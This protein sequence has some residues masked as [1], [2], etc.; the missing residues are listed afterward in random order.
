VIVKELESKDDRIRLQA[1]IILAA[2][3]EKARPAKETMKKIHAQS[4]GGGHYPMYIRWGLERALG[5]V[6]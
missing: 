2:L 4:R 6:K 3:G 5:N 1:T